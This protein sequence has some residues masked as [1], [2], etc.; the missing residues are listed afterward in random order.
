MSPKTISD[1]FTHTSD[2]ECQVNLIVEILDRGIQSRRESILKEPRQIRILDARGDVLD[3][4][5]HK[6]QYT[7]S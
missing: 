6:C 5:L 3:H 4:F 1:T 7:L 2:D